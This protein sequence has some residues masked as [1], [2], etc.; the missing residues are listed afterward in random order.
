M[1]DGKDDHSYGTP[2]DFKKELHYES[3]LFNEKIC[4][5]KCHFDICLEKDAIRIFLLL[6]SKIKNKE[7]L[8]L[9]EL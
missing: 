5:R 7:K 4:Y 8:I 1:F 3:N 2:F 9:S 6:L